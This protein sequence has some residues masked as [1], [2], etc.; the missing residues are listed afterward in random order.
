MVFLHECRKC[1][2]HLSAG[3]MSMSLH[4]T[5][6]CT[7]TAALESTDCPSPVMTGDGADLHSCAMTGL[8]G[9]LKCMQDMHRACLPCR[10]SQALKILTCQASQHC[11]EQWHARQAGQHR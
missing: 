10:G 3:M 11:R 2:F 4:Q 5:M 7:F 6:M 8:M 1:S 9:R